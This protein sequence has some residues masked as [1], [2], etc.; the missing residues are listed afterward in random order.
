MKGQT[1][2]TSQ[3]SGEKELSFENRLAWRNWL[4]A[5]AATEKGI[6]LVHF[7]KASGKPSVTRQEALE[8][9]LCF[10]WID[11]ILKSIDG[12]SYKQKY[13]PRARKSQ[14]SERNKTIVR[15]LLAEGKMAQPGL[16]SISGWINEAPGI[17][18]VTE[19]PSISSALVSAL[20][21]NNKASE[22][23]N[24]LPPSQQKNIIGWVGSCKKEETLMRRIAEV[25]A[26]LESGKG[27][28]MK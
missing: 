28:G 7:K 4:S 26:N 18:Q 3:M 27:I 9:A 19:N 25:I 14:W 17:K 11:S 22:T 24:L 10:G 20:Q 13:T 16:E 2:N 6:W 23:F 5:N 21:A 1:S 15:R 8:E 12:D